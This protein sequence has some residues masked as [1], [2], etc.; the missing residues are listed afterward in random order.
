MFPVTKKQF[1]IEEKY[2]L[3][4]YN[5]MLRNKVHVCPHSTQKKKQNR[6]IFK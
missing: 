4:P 2:N 1:I 5:A 3:S 6:Q